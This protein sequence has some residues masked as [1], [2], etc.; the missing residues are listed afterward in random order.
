MS[1]NQEP[2]VMEISFDQRNKARVIIR[3]YG[4]EIIRLVLAGLVAL[5]TVLCSGCYME[6]GVVWSWGS[7]VQ[8]QRTQNQAAATQGGPVTG[9]ASG[10][11]GTLD[12]PL[13]LP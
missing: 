10:G 8:A 12:V 3:R 7:N 13:P 4:A 6:S 5:L 1:E 9:P 2:P 11:T